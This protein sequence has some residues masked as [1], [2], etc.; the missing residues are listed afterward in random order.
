MATKLKR[1]RS[2]RERSVGFWR[3]VAVNAGGTSDGCFWKT[4]KGRL[5]DCHAAQSGRPPFGEI[6]SLGWRAY[7][8]FMGSLSLRR[9][10]R[11]YVS[12][13][14]LIRD[15]S[16]FVGHHDNVDGRGS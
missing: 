8:C 13:R 10:P 12:C 16:S 14:G 5:N 6:A 3:E 4:G 1:A 9:K 11:R 7:P 2:A 15:S